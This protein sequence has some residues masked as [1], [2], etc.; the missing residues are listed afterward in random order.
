MLIRA[1]VGVLGLA[2]L[3]VSQPAN[4]TSPGK[5]GPIA[6]MRQDAGGDWQI[7]TASARLTG[8]RQLTRGDADSGWPV[9]SPD[10][11][12]IAFGSSRTDPTGTG[13]VNDVFVMNAEGIHVRRLTG[14]IGISEN[15]AWSPDGKWIAF[16]SDQGDGPSKQDI[17]LVRST[18]GK[19]QR[20]T[21]L[22]HGY[23]GDAAPRFSPDG[24][25]LAFTRYRGT[26]QAERAA[27]FIVGRD[28]RHLHQLTPFALHAGD[29]DWSPDGTQIVFEAYPSS[30]YGDI[31]TVPAAGGK[32][33]NLTHDPYGQADPCWAP[34]GKKILFLDNGYVSGVGRTG[35]AT[36]NPDGTGRQF[37]SRQNQE[38]HQP[39][40]ESA[41]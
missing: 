7:W 5:D 4:A 36:M 34:D 15:P 28:G 10:G 3:L 37:L 12:S 27:L 1:V 39:D 6:Y 31:Y 40:W 25:R 33:L 22:P 24:T 29:A 38:L 18:G 35:L 17:Y 16:D 30:G 9:W 26:G 8:A 41:H 32:P 20:L 11:R 19:P 13:K 21:S 2:V 14:S 23:T